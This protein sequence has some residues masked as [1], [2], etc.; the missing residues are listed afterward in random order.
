MESEIAGAFKT[1][2]DSNA[3]AGGGEDFISLFFFDTK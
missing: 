1:T 3:G 2:E